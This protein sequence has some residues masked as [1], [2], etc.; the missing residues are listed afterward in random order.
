MTS[1]AIARAGAPLRRA[2][3][4]IAGAIVVQSIISAVAFA[5]L[6][7][8]GIG[9]TDPRI[10]WWGIPHM[11]V[12]AVWVWFIQRRHFAGHRLWPSGFRER[13]TPARPLGP[14]VAWTQ[15]ILVIAVIAAMASVFIETGARGIFHPMLVGALVLSL[16]IG[17]GEEGLYRKFILDRAG[18]S[19]RSKLAFLL[20]SALLF[21]FM[22]MTNV[23]AGMAPADALNQSL[24]AIPVG[25]F[26]GIVYLETRSLAALA[27]WHANVDFQLFATHVG[28]ATGEVLAAGAIIGFVVEAAAVIL[29]LGCLVNMGRRARPDRG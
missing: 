9:Y 12:T 3:A 22:H 8:N 24:L 14:V 25:L 7:R 17:F 18:E 13:E 21:G 16:L 29:L 26:A 15:R 28:D 10:L 20:A 23:S 5:V 11:V 6:H 27:L 19:R 4:E 1:H 2:V